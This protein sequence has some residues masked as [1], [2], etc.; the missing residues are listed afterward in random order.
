MKNFLFLTAFTCLIHCSLAGQSITKSVIATS[1]NSNSQNGVQIDWTMG[2][3]SVAYSKQG[4]YLQAG[5]QQNDDELV[6]V[7]ND[8]I[9]QAKIFPNPFS[10]ILNIEIELVAGLKINIYNIWGQLI[11]QCP[12]TEVNQ[13]INTSSWSV[14]PYILAIE[15][16][17]NVRITEKLIKHD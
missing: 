10:D 13:I 3:L 2:Q 1:G 12:T 16:P 14:G 15:A 6:L 5:F 17:N 4:E 8:G 11:H 9:I 7:D